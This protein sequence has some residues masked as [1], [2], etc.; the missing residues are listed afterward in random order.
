MNSECFGASR[1][2]AAWISAMAPAPTAALRTCHGFSCHMELELQMESLASGS[3]GP[4]NQRE[5]LGE[6]QPRPLRGAREGRSHRLGVQRG[7]REG[8]LSPGWAF[9]SF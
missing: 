1:K 4:A 5:G 8:Q 6:G 3:R 7:E 9:E 2:L